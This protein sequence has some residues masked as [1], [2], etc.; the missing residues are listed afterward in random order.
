MTFS[1]GK[2]HVQKWGVDPVASIKGATPLDHEYEPLL[3]AQEVADYLKISRP[4]VYKKAR[5]EGLPHMRLGITA[6]DMRFRMSAVQRWLKE[7]ESP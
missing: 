6:R 7:K 2:S 5:R 4:S 1:S 3:T